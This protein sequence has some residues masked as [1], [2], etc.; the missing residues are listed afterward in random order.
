M[1]FFYLPMSNLHLTPIASCDANGQVRYTEA[2]LSEALS[3]WMQMPESPSKYQELLLLAENAL[4]LSDE[5][6]ALEIYT[7]VLQQLAFRCRKEVLYRP[8]AD[9]AL[10]GLS[11]LSSSADE[12]VWEEASQRYSDYHQIIEQ[13]R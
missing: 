9:Q 11:S 4:G 2:Y 1:D 5:S 10:T 7:Y 13:A 8:F 12:Y 6:Q 3:D